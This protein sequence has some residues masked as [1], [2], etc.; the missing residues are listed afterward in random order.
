MSLSQDFFSFIIALAL[1]GAL[2]GISEGLK[3]IFN[4]DAGITRKLVHILT[5]VLIFFSPYYFELSFY[6]AL[7]PLL[8]IPFNVLAIKN[9]WLGS[10]HQ[11][12]SGDPEED[13]AQQVSYG[14]VY[15][16]LAFF[17]LVLLCWGEH[18]WIMQ[19]SM[20][21][22]GF[23]DA[24]AALVGEN[25]EK[26]HTF[27]LM[28]YKKTIEGSVAM[29]VTSVFVL[30]GSLIFF[31]DESSL[32]GSLN[33]TALIA[34]CIAIALVVTAVEALLS[35]GLDNLFIPLSVAYIL[36]IL[37]INGTVMY[38]SVLI[39]ISIALIF[40]RVSF[41]LKFLTASGAVGTFLFGSNIFSMGGLVW[42]IP[43]LT[44][45][46]LSSVLSKVGKEHKKK[47]DLIFEKS[48]QRDVGQ[49]LANGGVA[50]VLMIWFSFF[51][52]PLIFLAYLGTLAAVQADTWATEIGTMVKDPKPRYILNFKPV[53]AGT[54]GGITFTGTF[55][56]FVGALLIAASA[57]IIAPDQMMSVGIVESFLI[58]GFAGAGGSLVDSFF[59]ATVQAQY[60]DP[61]RKKTTERTHSKT[62]SGELIENELQ[63]G[64]RWIDN[65]VVNTMCATTGGILG[66]LFTQF[67][68]DPLFLESAKTASGY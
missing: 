50:W 12:T 36:A 65:D 45:F 40:A 61:I 46:I 30:V 17:I 60:Y 29:F 53:P 10:L 20:L 49:V 56:G 34:L 22:L 9:N 14:T 31:L 15:Y 23:G 62:E 52:D 32:I 3:K 55:G 51:Q 42:T 8:F 39:G 11:T 16:P 6:P 54:S 13:K 59:G 24:M 66:Y 28:A 27:K 26:P 47:Y 21:V 1:L 35:G 67:F 57:W 19:T 64:I 4:L 58:I 33:L 48:S 7:I 38:Q 37:E 43:V 68:A 44:F 41:A 5:S 63:K 2:I 25:S 18:V